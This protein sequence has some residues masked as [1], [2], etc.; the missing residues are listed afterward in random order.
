MLRV[1]SATL[2]ADALLLLAAAIWGSGFV[3]QRIGAQ[4][5]GPMTFNAARLAIG[6][7][8]LLPFIYSRKSTRQQRNSGPMT[9]A[10][11]VYLGGGL[12]AGLVLFLGVGLQ[13]KGMEYTPAGK[14]GFITGMYVVLVP[15]FGLFVRQRT[16]INTWAGAALS[17]IGLY[18]LSMS[19]S[20]EV[21]PGDCYIL[22]STVV[23]A[24]HVLV[25]GWLSP[26]TDPLKLAAMQFAVA[27]GL[28]LI[29]ALLAEEIRT[30]SLAMAGW[31][32]LYSG[33]LS[34]GVAF[35]LQ[36]V[37]QR[38]AP[39]AHAAIMLSFE[40][41]FA[42]L[43]GWLILSESLSPTELAGC[44]MMFVGIVVSQFRQPERA[45]VAPE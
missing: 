12:I 11:N 4:H 34:V 1:K 9:I 8:V 21:N 32:M 17:V 28:S 24:V 40:A 25:I 30:E 14:A 36:V 7:L 43:L 42:A 26:K 2:K 6:T 33:L 18:L 38:S 10:A 22:A 27:S 29:G 41:V 31:A 23:W 39:P 45:G 44:A 16:H 13:Q 35:T 3:A 15:A 20:L 19:G 37:G 5:V